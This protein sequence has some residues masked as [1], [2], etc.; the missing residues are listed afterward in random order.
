MKLTSFASFISSENY[1]SGRWVSL[2]FS[3][4][5]FVAEWD[6]LFV[7][8]SSHDKSSCFIQTNQNK[9]FELLAFPLFTLGKIYFLL[10][11]YRY[12]IAGWGNPEI[13]AIVPLGRKNG[14]HVSDFADCFSC[15]TNWTRWL[16]QILYQFLQRS[17]KWCMAWF[18]LG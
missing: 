2:Y 12:L 17:R 7:E 9:L 16:F 11:S 3:D 5:Q 8:N 14:T 6:L 1:K 4:Y 18:M 13:R 10:R 15:T